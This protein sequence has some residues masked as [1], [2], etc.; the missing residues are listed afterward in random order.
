MTRILVK[1]KRLRLGGDFRP[2]ELIRNSAVHLVI[3]R[4][5]Q[6]LVQ[7]EDHAQVPPVDVA[8]ELARSLRT[9]GRQR[10]PVVDGPGSRRL[11]RSRRRLRGSEGQPSRSRGGVLGVHGRERAARD[12]AVPHV[13]VGDGRRWFVLV[14]PGVERGVHLEVLRDV[15]L[16]E[17]AVGSVR[18]AGSAV[19]E[20]APAFVQTEPRVAVDVDGVEP[21]RV[22]VLFGRREG[23]AHRRS[24]RRRHGG[25]IYDEEMRE[26]WRELWRRRRGS[27]PRRLREHGGWDASRARGMDRAA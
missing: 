23:R 19:R 3:V 10:R 27:G 8:D 17:G 5:N 21:E 18:V 4:A 14:R 22:S 13:I 11:G 26:R 16:V 15:V 1:R 6:R 20:P 24:L 25:G 9:R 7:V 2:K 12:L